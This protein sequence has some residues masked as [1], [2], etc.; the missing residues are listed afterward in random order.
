[1]LQHAGVQADMGWEGEWLLMAAS[2]PEL[3]VRC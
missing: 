1:V 2:G 3:A